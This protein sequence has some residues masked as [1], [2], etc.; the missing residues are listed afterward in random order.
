MGD[1]SSFF[2]CL[3]GRT[4]TS[5]PLCS[6]HFQSSSTFA[7][8]MSL[9]CQQQIRRR[10]ESRIEREGGLW[11]RQARTSVVDMILGTKIKLLIV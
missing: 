7:L 11:R 6:L 8:T 10:S 3:P 1:K 4:H 5:L 9:S 2:S